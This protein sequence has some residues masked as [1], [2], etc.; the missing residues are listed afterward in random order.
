MTDVDYSP[1]HAS[2]RDRDQ[3]GELRPALPA[4]Q[5]FWAASAHGAGTQTVAWDLEDGD[6]SI[7][8]MN[9]DGSRGVDTDISAA[10]KVPFLGSLGWV[11]LGGALVLLITAGTLPLPRACAPP[12]RPK[13]TR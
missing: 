12:A 1:F 7:V 10:A 8:V 5:D 6:W 9:A 2:Y 3:G 13:P 4:D 11:S